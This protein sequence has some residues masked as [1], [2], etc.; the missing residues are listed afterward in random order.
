MMHTLALPYLELRVWMI[1]GGAFWIVVKPSSA[2]VYVVVMLGIGCH[3]W[4][5]RGRKYF[6]DMRKKVD[7]ARAQENAQKLEQECLDRLRIKHK[8][9]VDGQE[10]KK[11]KKR[12][13]VELE[14]EV[15]DDGD[16][17]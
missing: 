9:V 2:T 10:V 7:E 3:R 15:I 11:G 14:E 17:L 6:Q 16:E 1:L 8:I 12:K 4:N 13:A 5:E